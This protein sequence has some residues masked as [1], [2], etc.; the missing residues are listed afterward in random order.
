M[1]AWFEGIPT[2]LALSAVAAALSLIAIW[3]A[4]LLRVCFLAR[5]GVDA[6]PNPEAAVE[7]LAAL[8]EVAKREGLLSLESK[9]DPRREPL[10]SC[11]VALA[12]D[13]A[14]LNKIRDALDAEVD[15][16]ASQKSAWWRV[17]ATLPHLPG[18]CTITGSALLLMTLIVHAQAPA[19]AGTVAVSAGASLLFMGFMLTAAAPVLALGSSAHA[20]AETFS[21]IIQ[22][23]GAVLIC[24]GADASQVRAR[25]RGLLPA[26]SGEAS[27]ARAA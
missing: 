24:S 25:L 8:A 27:I 9:V 12:L 26:A 3:I 11:A 14:P 16:M 18:L 6:A 2:V 20:A 21:A 1:P 13:G 7:R 10:V 4:H 23:T 19:G 15:A 22:S 5:H 17:A